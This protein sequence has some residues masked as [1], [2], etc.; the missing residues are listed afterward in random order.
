LVTFFFALLL[1]VL[2]LITLRKGGNLSLL[3][4]SIFLFFG[5]LGNKKERAVY[6]KMD[7]S[8]RDAL[9]RGA[10]IKRVAILENRP[11]KDVFKFLT[12]GKYLVLEVYDEN[13]NYVFD[14]SQNEFS[15]L[16]LDANSPYEPIGELYRKNG[17]Q[18]R[19]RRK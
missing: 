9:V 4:F 5:G 3:F 18:D 16:F 19:K 1:L 8:V 12:Q 17:F 6:E 11:I 2:F 7:V 15:E 10:E 13:E 14:L